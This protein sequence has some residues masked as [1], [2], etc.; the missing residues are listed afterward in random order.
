MTCCKTHSKSTATRPNAGGRNSFVV[1]HLLPST[2]VLDS[3]GN[4][5]TG[6]NKSPKQ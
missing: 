5:V 2:T 1:E 6:T 3:S 4:K